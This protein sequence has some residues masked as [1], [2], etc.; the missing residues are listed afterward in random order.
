M[1]FFRA[2]NSSLTLATKLNS[3]HYWLPSKETLARIHQFVRATRF[4]LW[5]ELGDSFLLNET[6]R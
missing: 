6:N 2:T 4:I 3:Q 5:R 1:S